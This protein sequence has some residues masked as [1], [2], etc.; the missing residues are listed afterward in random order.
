MTSSI[1]PGVLPP[2][3]PPLYTVNVSPPS[4]DSVIATPSSQPLSVYSTATPDTVTVLPGLN[5]DQQQRRDPEDCSGLDLA[6]RRCNRQT[7]KDPLI[8]GKYRF[9]RRPCLVLSILAC[10]LTLM[11]LTVLSYHVTLGDNNNNSNNNSL[12]SSIGRLNCLPCFL[13]L[14]RRE[15]QEW[16]NGTQRQAT[17]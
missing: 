5:P 6:D 9:Y 11:G 4:Y 1:Q 17:N 7:P 12:T 2:E 15:I 3:A 8:C 16:V 10:V 13:K 14:E